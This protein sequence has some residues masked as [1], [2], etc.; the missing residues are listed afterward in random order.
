MCGRDGRGGAGGWWPSRWWRWGCGGRAGGAGGSDFRGFYR[1][2]RANLTAPMQPVRQHFPVEDDP[3]PYPPCSY[4]LFAPL[5]MLPLGVAAG[6]WYVLNLAASWGAWRGAEVLSGRRFSETREGWVLIGSVL[7]YWIGNMV[8]G[9][10]GPLLMCLVVWGYVAA[11]RGGEIWA[12]CLMGVGGLIKAIPALFLLPVVVWGRWRV[13]AGFVA[14]TGVF[15]GGVC[16]LYLG[17]EANWE[18]HARWMRMVVLGPENRPA[19]PLDP[20]SMHGSTRFNN[21]SVEGVCARLL[22][23]V[24]VREGGTTYVNVMSVE[25]G[26]WRMVTKGISLAVLLGTS[27]VLVV[28]GWKRGERKG[29]LRVLSLMVLTMLLISPIVWTHYYLWMFFPCAALMQDWKQGIGKVAGG[30][31]LVAWWGGELASGS[32]WCRAAGLHLGLVVL[33]W[34]Y[35]AWRVVLNDERV[36]LKDENGSM[37]TI[38]T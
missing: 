19:N 28:A 36:R 15:I 30:A 5:G 29:T 33:F 18:F 22:M 4:V 9:Q 37:V 27:V 6:M 8:S 2:W 11:A 26:T 17:P 23:R 35:F 20:D 25:P 32:M 13:I 16:T 12:G 34:V 24:P 31:L 1:I 10:N 14:L 38:T 21:Q 7:P 3:D